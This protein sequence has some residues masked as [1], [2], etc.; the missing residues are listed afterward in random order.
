M[1][2]F[3]RQ[4]RSFARTYGLSILV[5]LISTPFHDVDPLTHRIRRSLMERV[6]PHLE[7]RSPSSRTPCASQHLA[8]HSRSWRMQH[9]GLP[10]RAK[11]SKTRVTLRKSFVQEILWVFHGNCSNCDAEPASQPAGKWCA[12]NIRDGALCEA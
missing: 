10:R 12:F 7:T 2:S 8:Q 11:G 5:R 3:M 9:Y 6:L 1:T 4:L